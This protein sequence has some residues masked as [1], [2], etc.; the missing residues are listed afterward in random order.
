[1]ITSAQADVSGSPSLA[2]GQAG[3][4][5]KFWQEIIRESRMQERASMGQA[6]R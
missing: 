2:L 6:L 4:E 3:P 1:M 5:V